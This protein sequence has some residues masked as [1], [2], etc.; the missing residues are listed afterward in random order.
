M[1]ALEIVVSQNTG[2]GN[3]GLETNQSAGPSALPPVSRNLNVDDK[4][5]LRNENFKKSID[6]FLKERNSALSE[7]TVTPH[8]PTPHVLAQFASKVHT[9]YETGETDAQYETR[10]VLPDGW[11]LLTTASN[12]SKNNG[13][14][15]AAFWHPEHQQVVIA[16]R[17]S[18]HKNLGT[19]LTNVNGV[20]PN[21]C[22]PQMSSASTFAQKVVEVLQKCNCIRGVSFQLFFTGH[23]LGGWLAQ[24]TT[25]TT[26]YLKREGNIFLRSIVDNDSFHTHTVVFDSPS[27][28]DMLSVMRDTFDVRHNGRSIDLGH[29]DITSYLS[30]RNL[31]NDCNRYLGTVYCV[32]T[33]LR[34]AEWTDCINNYCPEFTEEVLQVQGNH[35]MIYQT[36]TYDKRVRGLS[37]FNQQEQQFLQDYRRLRQLPELFEP[38]EIFSSMR[39]NQAQEGAENILQNFEIVDQKVSCPDVNTLENFIPYVKRLLQ[40]F[41]QIKEST[42]RALSSHEARIKFYQLQTRLYLEQINQSPLHFK[43][44]VMS[45]SEILRRDQQQVI[46]LHINDGDEWTG[47]IMVYQ[48][49]QKNNCLCEGQ[50]IIL[51]LKCLLMVSQ[52]MD[53]NKLMLSIETP[54]LLLMA[55]E[56]NQAL[57][58]EEEEIFR[59]IFNTIKQKPNIKIFLTTQSR[60]SSISFLEEI[61][62]ETFGDGFVTINKQLTLSDITTSSQ[63]KLLEKS[64]SFQGSKIS[65]NKLVPT[66]STLAK[67]VPLGALLEG[68]QLAICEPMPTTNKYSEDYYIRKTLLYQKTIKQDIFKDKAVKEKH[69]FLTCGEQEFKQ[70][71]Q[72]YPNSNVHWLEKDKSGKFV[73][74]QS[75]GSLETL[76]RYIDTDISHRYTAEDLEKLLEQ[77][78]QQ[79]VMLISDTAGMSKSTVLRHLS[80]QIKQTFPAKWV[81]RIDLNDH[82][83][84]LKAME[85][86]HIDKEKAIEFVS[87]KLLKLNPGIELE[88]FKQ[89]C[90]QKQKISIVIMLDCCEEMSQSYKDTVIDLLQALRQTAVEQLWVTTQTNMT[91]ELEDKLQQLSYIVEPLSEENQVEILRNIWFLNGWL[92]ETK[93]ENEEEQKEKGRNKLEICSEELSQARSDKSRDI[94]RIQLQTPKLAKTFDGENESFS[95]TFEPVTF[96]ATNQTLFGLYERFVDIKHELYLEGRTGNR[97]RNDTAK[98]KKK[99]IVDCAREDHQL[100]ALKMLFDEEQVAQLQVENHFTLSAECLTEIGIAEK[101]CEGNLQFIHPTFADYFV[102]DFLVN[103]LTSGTHHS[104][105]LQDFL[106]TS[107]LMEPSCQAIRHF[108]DGLLSKSRPSK[109]ILNQYGNRM[110]EIRECCELTLYQAACEGNANIIGFCLESLEVGEHR[111]TI[112]ELLLAQD[113]EGQTAWHLAASGGNIKV[114]EKLWDWAVN[115]LAT[116]VLKNKLLLTTDCRGNT[117]WNVAARTGKAEVLQKIWELGKKALTPEDLKNDLFFSKDDREQTALHAAAELKNIE[118]LLKLWELAKEE[119]TVKDVTNNLLL[120]KDLCGLNAWFHAKEISHKQMLEKLKEVCDWAKQELMPEDLTDKYMLATDVRGNTAWHIAT[121]AGNIDF[122]EKIWEWAK[123]PEMLPSKLMLAK[124]ENEQTAFHVAAERSYTEVL[125]KLWDWAIENPQT[126]ELQNELLLSKTSSGITAWHKAAEL[127]NIEILHKIWEWAKEK[128]ESSDL[129]NK[130]LLATDVNQQNVLHMAAKGGDTK[131][132]EEIWEQCKEKLMPEDLKNKLLL[133][134]DRSEKTAWHTAADVGKIKILQ[135]IWEWAEEKLT[136]EEIN[137]KFLLGTDDRGSTGW[138]MAAERNNIEVLQK[139]WEWANRQLELEDLKHFFLVA[140][141]GIGKTAWHAAAEC[142]NTEVLH[143]LCKWAKSILKLDEL[144][145]ILL[146]DKDNEGRTVRDVAESTGNSELLYKLDEWVKERKKIQ[147]KRVALRR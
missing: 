122:L 56:N 31:I 10:L 16:H 26:E 57:N 43:P 129:E 90:E 15:G 34:S 131:V 97:I 95:Q 78:Q 51:T 49:L 55:C 66:D 82:I 48:V 42:K 29:L 73:W 123:G 125:E 124:D 142:G 79:R 27:C 74:Q 134:K 32:F 86:E 5:Q 93:N 85:Q 117:A 7:F 14:F 84:A 6:D 44:D 8:F 144:R 113:K 110:E 72:L 103:Q 47:L 88:L 24:V 71:C 111:D 63:E 21:Q 76:R 114:L 105:N 128:L 1:S 45:L 118:V 146:E 100:L 36:G 70:F 94:S 145:N 46:L 60:D 107:I 120:V 25:F 99:H 13:Y 53:L 112:N 87:E 9:D 64:V 62:C 3:L 98:R 127:G 40:L 141:D 28:K 121:E 138:H 23:S 58:G 33:D 65:L 67:L 59:T 81:V 96:L 147:K 140:K 136:T 116:K 89:C 35:P 102:A 143:K 126:G 37:V 109:E 68:K 18:V 54:Y 101:N 61:G 4:L 75:Q 139:I 52:L 77:A 41:P 83:D 132:L 20:L 38:K 135:K 12:I 19:L 91:E 69:V 137:N 130:F 104:Q 30:A 39:N 2:E 92:I 119:L 17:G 11:K 133:A 115:K 80:K 108:I 50:Y 22:V 106:L